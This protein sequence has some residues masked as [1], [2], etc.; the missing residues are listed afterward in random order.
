MKTHAPL[1]RLRQQRGAIAIIV[2]MSIVALIGFVGLALDLGKLFI[3]KTELQN[4]SDACALAASRE[5]TGANASQLEIAEAAGIT[6]GAV[7]RVIFQS[8]AV[9]LYV[10]DSVTFSKEYY[11]PYLAKNAIG[12][13]EALAMKYVR[14]TVN[15]AGIPN[16]FIQVLNVMPGINI[17]SQAVAA[18]A[19]AS[20]SPSQTNC[21]I[22]VALCSADLV[23]KKSGDWLMGAL[24]PK[25]TSSEGNLTGNFKWVDFPPLEGGGANELGGHLKGP[26]ACNLPATGAEVGEAGVK[27]SVSDEWNSRFGIYKGSTKPPPVPPDPLNP[28]AVPDFTGYA[29]TEVNWSTMA[30]A[31]T[32]SFIS[33][34]SENAMYIDNAGLV[35]SGT[36]KDS[37]YL[38]A[39]GADRRVVIAPVVDCADFGGGST[40]A[41]VKSW[42]CILMLHPLNTGEGAGTSTGT[43]RMYL[44]YLG[45]TGDSTS[46]CA[47]LGLSGSED[48]AGP[49]V[50][51]LVQ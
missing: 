29:Y 46:P 4:S 27:S 6:T 3:A 28:G 17:G 38:A 47:T 14:C 24:G 7:N 33:K 25:D 19:V 41:A 34:R 11:G 30:N 36:I 20:L 49:K 18:T 37:T 16:W 26:G 5:L 48:S 9:I 13:T 44:E 8:E 2:G 35:V 23:G 50:P 45:S 43:T 51:V 12:P 21:A 32:G 40:T 10:N 15:R 42:A 22:P 39:V 31:Y 1:P